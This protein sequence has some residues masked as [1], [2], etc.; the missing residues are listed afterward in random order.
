MKYLLTLII[1]LHLA[2]CLAL[3][4]NFVNPPYKEKDYGKFWVWESDS[5]NASV[6]SNEISKDAAIHQRRIAESQCL[7]E[8]HKITVPSPS[9]VQ[10]PKMSCQGQTGFALGF[11]NAYSPPTNC[12]YSAV[13]SAKQAQYE[14]MNSCMFLKGWEKA[15]YRNIDIVD[16][17]SG[18][19]EVPIRDINRIISQAQM[20][21]H[22]KK[23]IPF[24]WDLLIYS[25]EKMPISSRTQFQTIMERIEFLEMASMASIC[26]EFP[27]EE[28]AE[29]FPVAY[30]W[31]V[32]DKK[33]W[34]LMLKTIR[35]VD[36][37]DKDVSDYRSKYGE[38]MALGALNAYKVNEAI[39]LTSEV[40]I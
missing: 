23:N 35:S 15:Y 19:K 6:Q 32:S 39:R 37:S 24:A 10:P 16:I 12:D 30:K 3:N 7:M 18:S 31:K 8:A 38:Q 5:I 29:L 14:I 33:R 20:A 1:S 27:I 9:C 11:C 25:D 13:N 22:W 4:P 21:N 28:C 17:S 34:S 40:K 26:S 36:T 2:G